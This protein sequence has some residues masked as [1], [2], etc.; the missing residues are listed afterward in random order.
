VGTIDSD[1]IFKIRNGFYVPERLPP[2]T[3][4][5]AEEAL[6]QAAESIAQRCHESIRTNQTRE[7][8]SAQRSADRRAGYFAV[9]RIIRPLEESALRVWAK[10]N[11]L[12]LDTNEFTRRWHEQGEKGE[13]EHQIYYDPA[14][15]R[16]YKRNNL[17][18]HGNA[19]VDRNGEVFII[20]PVP[21][22]EQE[23]KLRRLAT[24]F[25]KISGSR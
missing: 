16:W 22:M 6:S 19:V 21:M 15:Q 9:N 7:F 1:V 11:N 12:L 8:T 17:C 18:N 3:P 24:H 20:D 2:E 25:N 23:S 13:T 5:Q 14:Q 10:Q 4:R